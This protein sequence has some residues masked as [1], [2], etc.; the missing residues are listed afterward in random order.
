GGSQ[1]MGLAVAR[2][3][4]RLGGSVCLVALDEL[5]EAQKYTELLRVDEGQFI[6]T[7]LCDTTDRDAMEPLMAEYIECR[8]IPD[9][10]FNFVGYAYAQYV[11][12]LKLDHFQQNMDVNYYGQ[13]VPALIILPYFLERKRGGHISFTSSILGCFGIM[14]YATYA[15]TKHALVGLAEVLRNELKPHAIKVSILYPPDT[16]TPGFNK[17]NETKPPE[18][19]LLSEKAKLL[20]PEAVSEAF[21]HGI[22]THRF[23]ILPGKSKLYWRLFRYLPGLLRLLM[24]WE[25]AKARKRL[26]KT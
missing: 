7:I 18:C 3:V 24:D 17:E 8:G 5:Q 21:I 10:L 23:Q 22:L 1:G 12:N 25:Y 15:P 6:E 9:Y 2:D 14:G 11:E 4:V 20:E 19:T 16:R 26:G 13:L